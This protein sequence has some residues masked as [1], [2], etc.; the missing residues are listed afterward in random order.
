METLFII[1]PDAVGKGVA[2]LITKR[3]QEKGFRII[4]SKTL[5]LSEQE[6]GEFYSIHKGK[7][8][9]DELVDFMT[10]GEIV[11]LRLEREDAVRYLREVVG[12][13]NPSN[14]NPGTI[15]KDFGTSV[16]TNAVHASDSDENAKREI[17]FF[18]KK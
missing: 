15:R 16:C 9:Y 14:A 17:A 1:K 2:A 5:K 6:A 11:V 13:T 7:P 10:S 3:I 8:F 4:D 18:F 12:A